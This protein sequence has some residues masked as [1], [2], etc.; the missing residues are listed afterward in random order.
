MNTAD[1]G[2]TLI[3]L[4]SIELYG[5]TFRTFIIFISEIIFRGDGLKSCLNGIILCAYEIAFHAND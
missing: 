4:N 2:V 3:A 1:L 5:G